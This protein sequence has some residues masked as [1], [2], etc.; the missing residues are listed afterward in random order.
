MITLS[1]SLLSADLSRLGEEIRCVTDAGATYIHIDVMDGAF[2]KSISY[3]MPVIK[4]IRKCTDAVF[5][6]HLMIEEPIRYIDDFAVSGADIITVHQEACKDLPA[7]IAAIKDSGKKA[8]VAIRPDTAVSVL[9]DIAG[10]VDMILVMT[11]YPG[12]GGQKFIPESLG[13]IRETKALLDSKGIK[14]MDIQVD[15][16]IY[17]DNVRDVL[18]AGANVI[19]AGS[20]VFR[21]DAAANVAGFFE[22]FKEYQ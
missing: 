13:R 17:L 12:F 9:E 18:D 1:P 14:D 8:G 5:D 11:V 22:I 10:L 15:G 4:S 6:V 7:T 20:S 21:G 3:G 2:V 19:V 16:G